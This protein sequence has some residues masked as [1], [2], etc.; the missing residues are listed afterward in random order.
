MWLETFDALEYMEGFVADSLAQQAQQNIAVLLGNSSVS[1]VIAVNFTKQAKIPSFSKLHVLVSI[2]CNHFSLSHSI[3][4]SI[5]HIAA[6]VE[7]VYNLL[8]YDAAKCLPTKLF[9]FPSHQKGRSRQTM[10]W[11]EEPKRQIR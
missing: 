8:H 11:K 6:C 5:S 7:H 1:S 4:S 10:A 3:L 9:P 2:F